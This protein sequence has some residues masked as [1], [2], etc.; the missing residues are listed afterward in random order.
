MAIVVH[1]VEQTTQRVILRHVSWETYERLLAEHE[2][3][4]SPRFTYDRGVLEI[5]SPSIKHERLNR[6]LATLCE[7]IAEEWHIDL[8]NAG[9]TTFKREAVACGFE[10]DSC[11]YVQNVERVRERDQI[12]LTVEPPPT[13]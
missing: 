4:S 11:F 3:C 12:D 1:P 10:P 13:S 5:M 2:Q 9:S 8:D 6:S 7:V